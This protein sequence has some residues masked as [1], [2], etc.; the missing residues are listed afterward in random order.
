MVVVTVVIVVVIVPVAFAAPSAAV[1]VPPPATMLPAPFTCL[2]QLVPFVS[3]LRTVPAVPASG[4]VQLVIR[5]ANPPLAIIRAGAWRGAKEQQSRECDGRESG[6]TEDET[7]YP[8]CHSFLLQLGLATLRGYRSGA[9]VDM[10][11]VP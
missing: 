3:G 7:C 9:P 11:L 8:V 5:S 6:L 4:F 10:P 2:H 1:F